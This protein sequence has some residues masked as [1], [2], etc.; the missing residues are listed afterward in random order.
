ML[1]LMAEPALAG[2]VTHPAVMAARDYLRRRVHEA[3][4]LEELARISRMSRFH[5]V[6]AFAAHIGLP[7]HA[8]QTRVRLER[9][10]ALLRAGIRPGEVANLTGFADQSHLTR[11]FRRIVGVTP[12]E[13]AKGA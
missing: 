2:H 5:L 9:A 11:H 3:I 6:R 10:M 12:G 13:Y 4:T 8:Y 1:H 7:P